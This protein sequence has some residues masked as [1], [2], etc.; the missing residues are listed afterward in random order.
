MH[1]RSSPT[2]RRRVWAQS[3]MRTD[4]RCTFS[5]L[6]TV[7][8]I[9]AS[10]ASTTR[11]TITISTRHRRA[12]WCT[13][14]T[15]SRMVRSSSGRSWRCGRDSREMLTQAGVP[16]LAASVDTQAVAAIIPAVEAEARRMSAIG[17]PVSVGL[18]LGCQPAAPPGTGTV[19]VSRPDRNKVPPR[20]PV[21][22][23]VGDDFA[24]VDEEVLDAAGLGI[25]AARRAPEDRCGPVPVRC[26]CG[27]DRTRRGRRSTPRPL[28]RG[29]RRP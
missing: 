17:H 4:C 12:T 9:C 23:I 2:A 24:A 28:V 19:S 22:L 15:R 6:P 29:A 1:A 8:S 21:K 13:T 7:T 11:R 18:T 26:R 10:T 27:R 3:S 20:S 16:D 5:A 14:T 25:Q